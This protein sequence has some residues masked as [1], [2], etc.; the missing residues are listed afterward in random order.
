MYETVSFSFNQAQQV[1]E[2]SR[3]QADSQVWFQQRAGRITASKL[4]QVPHTDYSQPSL[5]LVSSI[6]YP[7]K[8]KAMSI[9]CQYEC[10]HENIAREQFTESYRKTHDTFF[11]IKS[12]LILHPSY[13]FFGATPDGIVNCSC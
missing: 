10:E 13:L 4:W 6:C 11:V 5:S 9:A 2:M 1:E 7:D 8:H 3:L 12:G